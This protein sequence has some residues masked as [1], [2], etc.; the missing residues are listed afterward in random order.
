MEEKQL[1]E[2]KVYEE[3]L[4]YWPYKSSQ[5]FVLDKISELAP[6]NGNLLDIMCGPGN[7]L[8]RIAQIRPD[9]ELTG[10]DWKPEYVQYVGKKY[11][12]I[13]SIWG[14]VLDWHPKS[15]FDIVV[16]TG[17]LHHVPYDQQKTAIANIASMA[18]LGQPVIISDCYIDDYLNEIERKLAAEKLGH[19]YTQAAIGNGAPDDV[20]AW[21]LDITWNDVFQKEWKTSIKKR[22][23][24]LKECFSQIEPIKTW[25]QNSNYGFG[26]YIHICYV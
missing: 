17:A 4:L 13:I 12:R 14:N 15:L 21:T 11:P 22:L 9:L 24:F 16:C 5:Q 8:G 23:P 10:V 3:G 20:L 7:L 1:P 18:K 25:P 6:K 2:S 19:E 26:D